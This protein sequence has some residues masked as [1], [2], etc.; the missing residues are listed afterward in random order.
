MN[1]FLFWLT[2]Q[3]WYH[4][5]KLKEKTTGNIVSVTVPIFYGHSSTSASDLAIYE[6]MKKNQQT[7]NTSFIRART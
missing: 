1:N 2:S 5:Y 7:E 4:P 3:I 6:Q